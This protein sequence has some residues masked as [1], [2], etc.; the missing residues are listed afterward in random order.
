MVIPVDPSPRTDAELLAAHVGGDPTAFAELFGR[1]RRR[2]TRLAARSCDSPEDAADAL[3]EAMLAVHRSAGGFRQHAT[4]GSWLYR[5]VA[6]ACF[7]RRRYTAAHTASEFDECAH[8]VP[9]RTAQRDTALEVRAAL[10]ALPAAHRAAVLAVDLHGYSVADAAHVLGIP[11]GTVKSRR[12]RARAQLQ[13][14]LAPQPE[15]AHT[16]AGHWSGG[17]H[18]A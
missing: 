8:P 11:E 17:V 1:H 2:L 3:Q 4:V 16:S 13:R 12:A 10:L 14:T 9:D 15:P 18:S 5:I 7:D 6:N